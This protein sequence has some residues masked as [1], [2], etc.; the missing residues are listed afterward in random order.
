[1]TLRM[2]VTAILTRDGHA[3]SDTARSRML[4][5]VSYVQAHCQAVPMA[6]PD[7][8]HLKGNT[9]PAPKFNQQSQF[10]VAVAFLQSQETLWRYIVNDNAQSMCCS[11]RTAQSAFRNALDTSPPYNNINT[12]REAATILSTAFG[13]PKGQ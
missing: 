11:R 5:L 4:L 7:K 9:R 13:D 2:D 1:M 12:A 3:V 10:T 8:V 6:R